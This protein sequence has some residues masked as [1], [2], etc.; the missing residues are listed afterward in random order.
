MELFISRQPIFAL[1]EQIVAYSVSHYMT[2]QPGERPPSPFADSAEALL[3][4]AV[5]VAGLERIGEGRQVF[6]GAPR[7]LLLGPRARILPPA[8]VVLEV[9]AGE[10]IDDDMEAACARLAADGHMLALVDYFPGAPGAALLPHVQVVKINASALSHTE[11]R[12]AVASLAGWPIMRVAEQ[13]KNRSMRDRCVML[14]FSHF[15]GYRFSRPET[16]VL[17]TLGINEVST[18]RILK[19]LADP[20]VHDRDIESVFESDVEL[21]YRLL[22]IVNSAAVGSG[23]IS[24]VGNAMR[25]MG[26]EALHRWFSLSLLSTNSGPGIKG[27]LVRA[28]LVRASLCESLAKAC[29][30]PQAGH[31][32]FLVGLFSMLD[33]ITGIS[34]EELMRQI[35]P[36]SDIREALLARNEWMGEAL[37]LVEAWENAS[38]SEVLVRSANIGMAA[39]DL[40]QLYSNAIDWAAARIQESATT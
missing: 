32:L 28:S 29:G 26:R 39:L 21:S 35:E 34:M 10:P 4:D 27:E 13:V 1:D 38:W 31:S 36:A 25:L 3:A 15:Q 5:L 17:R 2:E 18:F 19:A 11:L 6:F 14:G 7:E 40:P 16:I 22:R 33:V 30:I 12:E 23:S 9:N 8:L 20:E 24:S 37:A